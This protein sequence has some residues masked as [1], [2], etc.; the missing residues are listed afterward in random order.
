MLGYK[1][2]YCAQRTLAGIELSK[3]LRKGQMR[4][5]ACLSRPLAELFYGPA[6][7]GGGSTLEIP[8][9]GY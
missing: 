7:W 2:F 8:G 3:M 1:N 6:A 9:I 5:Q 4:A